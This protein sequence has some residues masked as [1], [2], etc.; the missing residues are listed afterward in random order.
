MTGS[1]FNQSLN[2][3]AETEIGEEQQTDQSERGVNDGRA[4]V[5]EQGEAVIVMLRLP[6]RHAAEQAARAVRTNAFVDFAEHP[7]AVH[8]VKQTGERE[9][10]H[11][12]PEQRPAQTVA[13][14]AQKVQQ[15]RDAEQRQQERQQVA[16]EAERQERTH[17]RY[18]PSGPIQFSVGLLTRVVRNGNVA[19]VKRPLRDKQQQSHSQ[20]R[21]ADDVVEAVVRFGILP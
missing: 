5:A 11:A 13:Q 15:I 19:A 9:E 12:R 18:A 3:R 7:G 20:Q 16:D 17:A 6:E 1:F 2:P 4:E 21:D 8:H 10:Q 14:V